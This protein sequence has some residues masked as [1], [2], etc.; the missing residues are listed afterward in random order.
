MLWQLHPRL[1]C[2]EKDGYLIDLPQCEA[3]AK[4]LLKRTI[5]TVSFYSYRI[6]LKQWE[7]N[8]LLY[9]LFLF[10][11]FLVDMY[12]CQNCIRNNQAQVRAD[13]YIHLR[14]AIGRHDVEADQLDQMVVLPWLITCNFRRKDVT[15]VL[16]FRQK[17]HDC[18]DIIARL[19]HLKAK[20]M[21]ALLTKGKIFGEVS[22]L[23]FWPFSILAKQTILPY[24]EVPSYCVWTNKLQEEKEEIV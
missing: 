14:D 8:L 11:Q 21:M 19:F 18:H 2:R 23:I 17:V 13:S 7:D 6:I 20:K 9:F 10:S 24:S 16:L 5:P 1:F 4:L 3:R 12:V 22:C 15:D